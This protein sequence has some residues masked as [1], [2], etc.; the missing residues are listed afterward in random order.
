M[1][2]H[3]TLCPRFSLPYSLL[4]PPEETLF[5]WRFSLPIF[6][7]KVVSISFPPFLETFTAKSFELVELFVEQ[8]RSSDSKPPFLKKLKTLFVRMKCFVWF[9]FLES[10][11]VPSDNFLRR[12]HVKSIRIAY[13]RLSKVMKNSL[14]QKQK[15]GGR[16]GS[17]FS[18]TKYFF[19][20]VSRKVV[21]YF[22]TTFL[23]G[24]MSYLVELV[25]LFHEL[26]VKT[27]F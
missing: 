16:R 26:Y 8:C 4:V 3:P 11:Y 23:V 20:K 27:W 2:S 6:S 5:K 24:C 12:F 9:F 19:M 10:L 25:K 17:I 15:V 14:C 18:K 21:G 1:V 22:G 13:D 7:D